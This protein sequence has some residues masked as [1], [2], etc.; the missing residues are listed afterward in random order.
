MSGIL[1]V[2]QLHIFAPSGAGLRLT[3]S[4][5]ARALA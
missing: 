3:G 2:R 4:F 5:G 1:R